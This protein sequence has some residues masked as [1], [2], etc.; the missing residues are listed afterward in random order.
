MVA[1]AL[2]FCT[3]LPFGLRFRNNFPGISDNGFAAMMAFALAA[4]SFG[5]MRLLLGRGFGPAAGKRLNRVDRQRLQQIKE[6]SARDVAAWREQKRLRV[7]E[8]LADPNKRPYAALVERGEEWSDE[9]IAYHEHPNRTATCPHLQP[10]ERAI[11]QA[12]IVPKLLK[13]LAVRADCCIRNAEL[14]RYF[15]LPES[16][17][18]EEG[19]SP[20]RYYQDNP[21]ARLTCYAC[22]S[23]IDLV[24]SE[25]PRPTTTWFPLP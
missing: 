14:R 16:V 10:V 19:Y 25:W 6:K 3:V 22:G 23:T 18:Y 8:L 11:R 13:P 20:E 7:A 1:V 21:W 4:I 5:V 2:A 24:H 17:R 15:T 9:Q 12:G